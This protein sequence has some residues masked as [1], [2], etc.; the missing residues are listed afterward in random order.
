MQKLASSTSSYD[1]ELDDEIN[2]EMDDSFLKTVFMQNISDES[3]NE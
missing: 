2:F 1:K 3:N